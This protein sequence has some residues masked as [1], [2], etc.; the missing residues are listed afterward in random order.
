[1]EPDTHRY[2]SE[3]M[4]DRHRED[5]AASDN[6]AFA[7]AKEWIPALTISIMLGTVGAYYIIQLLSAVGDKLTV[8]LRASGAH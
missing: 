1:M 6:D 3:R 2:S 7:R 4:V 8:A 5:Q